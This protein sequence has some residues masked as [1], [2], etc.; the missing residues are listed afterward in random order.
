[1]CHQVN[2]TIACFPLTR[3]VTIFCDQEL[4]GGLIPDPTTMIEKLGESFNSPGVRAERVI[5][6]GCEERLRLGR[7]PRGTCCM[8]RCS[9]VWRRAPPCCAHP[10]TSSLY[11]SP[12]GDLR[13]KRSLDEGIIKTLCVCRYRGLGKGES[14]LNPHANTAVA[15]TAAPTAHPTRSDCHPTPAQARSW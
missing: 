13:K 6:A 9:G 14:L 1:M 12:Q 8:S 10:A 15:P 11:C 7:G 5:D 2:H 3:H 4:R